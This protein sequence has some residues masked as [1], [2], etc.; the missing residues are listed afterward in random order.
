MRARRHLDPN[1]DNNRYFLCEKML[2][3]LVEF[4]IEIKQEQFFGFLY[5]N[6]LR[7]PVSAHKITENRVF[8][9]EKITFKMYSNR[10]NCR[11]NAFQFPVCW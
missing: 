2:R 10:N 7:K 8:Y 5:Y 6:I 9:C 1:S 3:S 11:L 4:M